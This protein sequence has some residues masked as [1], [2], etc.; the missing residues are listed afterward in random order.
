MELGNPNFKMQLMLYILIQLYFS[1]E[2]SKAT[3]EAHDQIF[4]KLNHQAF[5]IIERIKETGEGTYIKIGNNT[6]NSECDY[7]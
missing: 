5:T 3:K 4:L 1:W 7:R 2:Y 6:I